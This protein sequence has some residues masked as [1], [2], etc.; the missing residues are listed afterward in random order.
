LTGSML[1]KADLH[2]HTPKS[3]CY[4]DKTVTPEQIVD[5]ALAAG[6]EVIAITDH[7][8]TAATG[9]IREIARRKGLFVFPGAELT[10]RGGHFVAL[11][12]ID[13]P[14]ERLDTFLDDLKIDPLRRGD[15]AC[16]VDGEPEKILEAIDSHG[17]IA[18]AAHIERWPSGFLE[19][20]EPRRSKMAIHAS[21][22]LS[23]LEITVPGDRESWNEGLMRNFPKKYACIQT[24]DAHK[25]DEI[26]R[27]PVYIMMERV[28]LESLR[29]AFTDFREKI[30]F[31]DDY[32]GEQQL[33]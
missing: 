30:A 24:S 13:T 10:T 33:T 22:Y 14:E 11:F 3:A 7:N 6:L 16:M 15:G 27:R 18:I 12:D 32:N 25:P 28:D 23:A 31:P 1:R 4:S 29:E 5:A 2:I 8:S 19:A 20:N 26:G 21:P 9:E 17:G